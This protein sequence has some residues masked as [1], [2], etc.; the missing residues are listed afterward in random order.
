[1]AIKNLITNDTKLLELSEQVYTPSKI[2]RATGVRQDICKTWDSWYNHN[3]KWYF[4]KDFGYSNQNTCETI[5]LNELLGEYLATKLGLDTVHY[6]MAKLIHPNGKETIGLASEN[7]VHKGN[8]YYFIRDMDIS[9]NYADTSNIN[10][11]R[12]ICPSEENYKELVSEINKLTALDIF[13]SQE[14]R[15]EQNVQFRKHKK[16]L[17]LAPI[18]D[19]E[20]SFKNPYD[21]RYGSCILGVNVDDAIYYPGINSELDKLF[22]LDM[23]DVLEEIEEER[24]ITIPID[25]KEHYKEFVKTRRECIR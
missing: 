24:K 17:H 19:Y 15:C 3:G 13:M 4:Y 9:V 18:Y 22:S 20:F 14:D 21:L 12:Y 10:R 7:F 8:K 11:F 25:K 16:E 2:A 23:K 5:F 1:M 6:E